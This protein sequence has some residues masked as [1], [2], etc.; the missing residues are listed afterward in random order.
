MR[1]AGKNLQGEIGLGGAAAALFRNKR[2]IAATTLGAGAAALLF[3]AL[4]E[5]RYVAQSRIL[6]EN[7]ESLE[8]T[9]GGDVAQ[10]PDAEAANSQIQL[11]TSRDLARKAIQALDL[12]SNPEFESSAPGVLAPLVW[13]GVL[14][15]PSR[16][17]QEDRVLTHYFDHLT[18]MSP[19]RTRVLQ[20]EFFSRDPDLAARGANIVADLYM[21]LQTQAKRER[22]RQAAQNLKPLIASLEARAAQ[23]DAKVEAFR[24]NVENAS[25]PSQQLGEIAARLAEARTAQSE[26]EAKA[27]GMREALRQGRL[28]DAGDI[29]GNELARRI[30]EQRALL[31]SQL[32]ANSRT[33]LPA[34]PRMKELQAQLAD[35]ETQL[36]AAVEKAA[37]G[38]DNDARV[39]GARAASLAG[40]MEEQ[41]RA[42]GAANADMAQLR[43]LERNA[44]TLHDQLASE[45]AKFQ[46]ALAR[47]GAD[48]APD[49]RIVSRALSPSQPVFPNKIA[50]TV[51]AAL[52]GLILSAGVVIRRAMTAPRGAPRVAP[53]APREPEELF[54][55]AEA[56][57]PAQDVAGMERIK[58]ALAE[59]D[60][61]ARANVAPEPSSEAEEPAPL[62]IRAAASRALVERIVRTAKSRGAH[63]LIASAEDSAPACAGLAL[64]RLLAREGRTILLQTDDADPFLNE[65]LEVAAGGAAHPGLA[66][67]LSGAASFADAIYRDDVSRLHIVQAGGPVD[68]LSTD[69]SLILDALQATYDFV[70][71]AAGANEEARALAAESDLTL[72][73]AGDRQTRDFLHDDFEASGVRPIVLAG[74]DRSGEIVEV[75]A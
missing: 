50:I 35:S 60:A 21:A 34:H 65:A 5:P 14:P 63:V 55:R 57:A 43:E 1:A 38:L 64:A 48:S 15:D 20:V 39:A 74:L 54:P 37:R 23:A 44:R 10:A 41:K 72:I 42:V 9:R 73:F 75:A 71:I 59:F 13:L 17:T 30:S 70:V 22:A 11:L 4:A 61:P 32:A 66:H 53:P 19:A 12:Q 27:R 3:C 24:H 49:A 58:Q 36:R 45:A 8:A 52:A 31:Q 28:A 62:S 33:L 47:D 40:S 26:A 29:S 67:L 69:L 6:I 56:A 2:M 18:V 7:Q 51:L 16:Q 68:L 46:A 25:V